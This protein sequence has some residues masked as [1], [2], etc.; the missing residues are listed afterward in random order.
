MSAVLGVRKQTALLSQDSLRDFE[1]I[2][3]EWTASV[4]SKES[5][6]HLNDYKFQEFALG[7]EQTR[8]KIRNSRY[9]RLLIFN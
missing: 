1:K 9:A 4:R 3:N 8:N 7:K 5:F 6:V 2:P